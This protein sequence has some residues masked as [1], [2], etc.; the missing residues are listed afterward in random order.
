MSLTPHDINSS[1]FK[2]IQTDQQTIRT[3]LTHLDTIIANKTITST[4]SDDDSFCLEEFATKKKSLQYETI[5]PLDTI[6]IEFKPS[7]RNLIIKQFIPSAVPKQIHYN[8]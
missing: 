8:K 1:Q 3:N 7:E 6:D 2:S 5:G 4:T